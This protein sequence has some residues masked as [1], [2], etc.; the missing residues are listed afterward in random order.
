VTVA[1]DGMDAHGDGAMATALRLSQLVS[2]DDHVVEVWPLPH[3]VRYLGKA[4]DLEPREIA[5]SNRVNALMFHNGWSRERAE[6][7]VATHPDGSE[8]NG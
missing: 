2:T 1:G 7:Y 8:R 5:P 3:D 4:E 6:A